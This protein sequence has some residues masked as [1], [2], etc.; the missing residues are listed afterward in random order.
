MLARQPP[1]TDEA[2]AHVQGEQ[3]RAYPRAYWQAQAKKI[4]ARRSLAAF[5][6]YMWPVIEP[7]QVL[8]WS[9]HIDVICDALEKV[10]RGEI[11][12]LLINIP[13]GHMKSLLVAVFWPA[14]TWL[15]N[16]G[17]RAL[18]ATYVQKLSNRD[19]LRCRDLVRST[20]Y[21]ELIPRLYGDTWREPWDLK[22][23][24]NNVES[25]STTLSGFRLATSV[26]G[27]GTGFRGDAIV[28]DDPLN[29]EEFPTAEAL[30]A[31][32]SWYDKRMSSRFNDQDK[33]AIVIIMQR[34][35]ENDLAGHVLAQDKTNASNPSWRPFRHI[36]LRSEYDPAH[37]NEFDRR[38]EHG[39]LLFPGKFSRDV[40]EVAKIQLG[41]QYP[42]QHDQRPVSAAGGIFPMCKLRFWYPKGIETIPLPWRE[43]DEKGNEV[44]C[45]QGELPRRFDFMCQSWDLAFKDTKTSD[46]VAGQVWG[47]WFAACHLV[48]QEHGHFGIT[49]SIERIRFTSSTFP[50]ATAKYIEDKANG[51]AVIEMLQH[52]L[53]GIEPVEPDGGKVA[54]AWA[55][56]PLISAGNVWLPHP[57][58]YPWVVPLLNELRAFPRGRHDDMVDAFTQALRK[59]ALSG[60]SLLQAMTRD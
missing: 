15:E 59:L 41:A 47:R 19:S 2:R 25:Y 21:R 28:I 33:G 36:C 8:V 12:R 51:P 30:E 46:F 5:V 55:V 23:D 7:G 52:E 16:P 9:W 45:V 40:I 3:R 48:H 50:Q 13:P 11:T 14:W 35:H 26:T 29:V 39:E 57:A 54:R 49:K 6:R 44:A 43:K 32:T 20:E 22:A 1:M 38:K 17:F 58:L 18:F 37:P 24:A 42:A 53:F 56:E 10:T 60:A 4:E 27:A 34:L 31:V